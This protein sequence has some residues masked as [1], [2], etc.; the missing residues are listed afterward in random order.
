MVFHLFHTNLRKMEQN[1]PFKKTV[2][3]GSG[4]TRLTYCVYPKKV[5]RF[6]FYAIPSEKDS[7]FNINHCKH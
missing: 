6:S 3:E 7:L 4:K 5:M 2:A 1:D